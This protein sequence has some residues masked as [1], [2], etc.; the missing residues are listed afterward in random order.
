M[1]FVT[2]VCGLFCKLLLLFYAPYISVYAIV[3]GVL[4]YIYFCVRYSYRCCVLQLFLL[5]AT[6]GILFTA[7]S[8]PVSVSYLHFVFR[9]KKEREKR[10]LRYS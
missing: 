6:A 5:Y 7:K 4:C 3:I 2:I 1:V 8:K 9:E 10:H